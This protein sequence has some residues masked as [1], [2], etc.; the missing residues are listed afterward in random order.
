LCLDENTDADGDCINGDDERLY[1]LTD[2]N[3]NVTAIISNTGEAWERYG[4]DA[5][6]R[7]T[8]YTS[9]WSQTRGS[10]PWFKTSILF[11]GY[12]RDRESELYHVRNRAYH[13]PLG[14]WMQRDRL[15]YVDG[16]SVYEYVSGRPSGRTDFG[17]TS[18]RY[19]FLISE[20]KT[21]KN[22]RCGRLQRWKE[23]SG[24]M[25][26]PEWMLDCNYPVVFVTDRN[27]CPPETG[28]EWQE[29][30]EDKGAVAAQ[31]FLDNTN[32][33]GGFQASLGIVSAG[34]QIVKCTDECNK[35]RKMTFAKVCFGV[36]TP[37]ITASAGIVQG[38]AKEK[39]NPKRYSRFFAEF[40]VGYFVGVGVDAGLTGPMSAPP[41]TTGVVQEAV[42]ASSGPSAAA[43]I[44][45]YRWLGME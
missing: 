41:N 32:P 2:A 9:D 14:R 24:P 27:A 8:V 23:C 34:Y 25:W 21:R 19:R 35:T 4:Y 3:M 1:Y 40:S 12:F 43:N 29:V 45:Y 30:N 6:G 18:G 38:M 39:C 28:N 37:G 33:T 10:T 11:A 7:V 16:M 5:Y 22:G 13:P 44:C 31:A 15:G 20:L 17:G 42:E 36:S 26:L